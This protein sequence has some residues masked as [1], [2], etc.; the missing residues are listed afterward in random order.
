[1]TV[2]VAAD[3]QFE[4]NQEQKIEKWN[5]IIKPE[6]EVLILGHFYNGNY[7]ELLEKLNGQKA[8]IDFK[9]KDYENWTKEKLIEQGFVRANNTYGY[10]FANTIGITH[11]LPDNEK[12][13]EVAKSQIQCASARSITKQNKVL[14]NNVLSLSYSDWDNCPI[15]Y[16]RI[17]VLY[18]NMVKFYQMGDDGSVG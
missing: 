15:E 13:N 3:C 18:E 16:S 12:L 14:E 5:K 4:D 6:D 9:N 2:W 17:P 8:I 1:M 11:I 10:V 7:K